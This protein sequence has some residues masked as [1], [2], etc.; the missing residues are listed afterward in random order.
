M[1]SFKGR[2]LSKEDFWYQTK[3][4]LGVTLSKDELDAVFDY[5]DEDGGGSID[6]GEILYKF[7]R[8]EHLDL[9]MAGKTKRRTYR[10]GIE[11]RKVNIDRVRRRRE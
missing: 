9:T 4:V 1:S 8:R 5:F 6:Y 2:D 3:V 10:S 11:F 7:H